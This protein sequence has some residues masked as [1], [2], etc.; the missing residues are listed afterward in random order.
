MKSTYF[1]TRQPLTSSRAV[2]IS[3]TSSWLSI[4]TFPTTRKTMCTASAVPPAEQ[5]AKGWPSLSFQPKN[6]SNS[7]ASKNSWIRKS[8]K[9]RSIPNS[10]KHLYTSPKNTPTCVVAED[11]PAKTAEKGKATTAPAAATTNAA[12]EDRGRKHR[13]TF[14]N[15][16]AGI[17]TNA[18]RRL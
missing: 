15:M 8:I 17:Y 13:L 7:N 3:T 5:T 10:A 6:N 14:I 16:S 1:R 9:Y 12:E 11:A 18:G 4:S 2:S